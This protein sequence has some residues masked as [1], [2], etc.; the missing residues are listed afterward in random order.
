MT[1][2]P[3]SPSRPIALQRIRE[4]LHRYVPSPSEQ[5]CYKI[6]IYIE[7]IAKW[8]RRMPLTTIL[9]PEEIVRFHFGESIFALSVTGTVRNGRLAD[10]GTGAG[11]P[12]LALK[13]A[14]EAMPVILIESN[15]RKCAFLHEV[16]RSL[17]LREAEVVSARFEDA[18]VE[19]AT[20]SVVTCRALGAHAS[21]LRWARGKLKPGGSV[22]LWLG[23]EDAESIPRSP[24][25]QWGQ[26]QLIPD[27]RA[28]YILKGVR[29]E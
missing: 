2:I 17:A 15:R 10:V 26:P 29:G 11:F 23:E 8:C 21:L 16:I 13:M 22:V 24:G 3:V 20:L 14:D 6:Q 25:W 28:R 9:D 19:R 1:K 5:V 7:L 4:I 27:T 18:E 12:G